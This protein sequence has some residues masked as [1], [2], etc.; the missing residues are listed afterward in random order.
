[1]KKYTTSD[2][3]ATLNV[4]VRTA[5]RYVQS[6][7][8]EDKSF[9]EDVF[10]LIIERHQHDNETTDSDN[11]LIQEGFTQSEY[12]MFKK[13]LTE[14]PLLNNHIKSLEDEID[15]H[16]SKYDELMR[17]H[18]QFITMHTKTLDNISQRNYIEAKEKN[19]R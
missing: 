18:E 16:R 1:M 5:Q 6:I 2:I 10:N 3:A 4:H 14:Y 15:Y 12:D 19:V 11:E 8:N 7:I 13:W 9:N 17:L